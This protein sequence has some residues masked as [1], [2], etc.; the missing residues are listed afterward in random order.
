LVFHNQIPFWTK[1]SVWP[2]ALN[3]T[4][5]TPPVW[6]WRKARSWPVLIIH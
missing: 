4:E 6:P 1:A 3:A 5:V 2:S